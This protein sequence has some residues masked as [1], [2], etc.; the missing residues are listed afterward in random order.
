MKK[1]TLKTWKFVEEG[2]EWMH[3]K[4]AN[5]LPYWNIHHHF[6]TSADEAQM[7]VL[8]PIDEAAYVSDF[9]VS[10]YHQILVHSFQNHFLQESQQLCH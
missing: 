9:G 7:L 2:Y 3:G 1:L 8:T 4:H 10:H 6:Q 5:L